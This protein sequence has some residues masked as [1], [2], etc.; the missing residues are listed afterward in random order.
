[1]TA[2]EAGCSLLRLPRGLIPQLLGR[3]WRE[4]PNCRSAEERAALAARVAATDSALGSTF[5]SAE[6][7]DQLVEALVVV[8]AQPG[9]VLQRIGEPSIGVLLIEHGAVRRLSMVTPSAYMSVRGLSRSNT[10][11]SVSVSDDHAPKLFGPGSHVGS[12]SPAPVGY[13]LVA[14]GAG[15]RLLLLPRAKGLVILAPTHE[16][17]RKRL[18]PRTASQNLAR[19]AIP[20]PPPPLEDL[21]VAGLLG[22]GGMGKV[23]LVRMA[24]RHATRCHPPS[25]SSSKTADEAAPGTHKGADALW[26]EYALKFAREERASVEL[27]QRE[28]AVLMA[29]HHPFIPRIYGASEYFLLTQ[30]ARGCEL[31]Y[32]LREVQRFEP[33]T[34]AL[35]TAMALAALVHLHGKHIAHRDLKP[36]NLVLTSDGYLMLVDFG[37]SRP[38]GMGAERAWTICGTPEYTAPEVI[39][40]VGHG[41]EVDL[42]AVGVLVFELLSG[43]PPFC[44]DEPI[45]VYA[46]T[47]QGSPAIPQS[48]PPLACELIDELLRAEPHMRLGAL[49]GFA[50]DVSCHSFFSFVDWPALLGRQIEVPLIPVIADT[51]RDDP[52][53]LTELEKELF[54]ARQREKRAKEATSQQLW[55]ET[56]SRA[57]FQGPVPI[58]VADSPGNETEPTC[59]QRSVSSPVL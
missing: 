36:E 35:Y 21:R 59:A 30:V 1:V 43:Y 40:G 12:L 20:P 22:E 41:L 14:A 51:R 57:P 46:A 56:A 29:C 10:R 26:E 31:F 8:E 33:E 6:Q 16:V 53:L 50:V 23:L 39:R 48:V 44:A 49:G 45:G 27:L 19:Q 32:L 5:T 15:L 7:R 11:P 42:W 18:L 24:P 58:S 3:R 38:L 25:A 54:K 17:V 34:A 28:R 4:L 47:L 2:H 37:L 55:L 9:D 52:E 13:T